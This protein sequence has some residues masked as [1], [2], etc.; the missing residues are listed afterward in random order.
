MTRETIPA[1]ARPNPSLED[2]KR[3]RDNNSVTVTTTMTTT[4]T[5]AKTTTLTSSPT[6]P[7]A[8]S[9]GYASTTGTD[10]AVLRME[11]YIVSAAVPGGR[12]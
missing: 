8:I 10:H 9:V 5:T 4:K 11:F 1:S 12:G 7:L 2:N 6:S 3:Y